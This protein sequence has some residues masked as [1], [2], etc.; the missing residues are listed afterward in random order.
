M[1]V[2]S[3]YSCHVRDGL[4]TSAILANVTVH[5]VS[6]GSLLY[7]V[8]AAHI[9]RLPNTCTCFIV[10][11]CARHATYSRLSCEPYFGGHG[12]FGAVHL[13]NIWHFLCALPFVLSISL[14]FRGRQLCPSGNDRFLSSVCQCTD[15]RIAFLTFFCV[16][17]VNLHSLIGALCFI[18]KL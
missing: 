16:V 6:S 8:S 14:Y 2:I 11:L 3:A 5:S 13:S 7:S 12:I 10:F 17:S 9:A 18:Q 15:S 1:F 4:G